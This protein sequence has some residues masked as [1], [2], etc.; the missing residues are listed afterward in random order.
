MKGSPWLEEHPRDRGVDVLD[1][2]EAADVVVIGGGISGLSVA[3]ELLDSTDLSV[4]LMERDL[5]GQGATGHNGGQV[6]AAF[7]RRFEGV[8][9][10]MGRERAA[11]GFREVQ[12]AWDA[13][14]GMVRSLRSPGL[15]QMVPS[16]LGIASPA[17]LRSWTAERRRRG[18]LGMPIGTLRVADDVPSPT[19]SG[20]EKVPREVLEE[21]L[22]TRDRRY[23][24]A[25]GMEIGLMNSY[26]FIELLAKDLLEQHPERFRLF[27]RSPAERLRLSEEEGVASC[28][29]LTVRADRVVLCTNGYRAPPI[30]AC[31]PP[32]ITGRV[33]GVVGYMVGS[34]ALE[35]AA[36]ARAYFRGGDEPYF[37]LTRRE[38]LGGWLTAVGGPEGAIDG[39][40]DPE[41]AYRP[42]AF[43]RLGEFIDETLAIPAGARDHRWQGL[44]GYTPSGVRAV[45]RDPLLPPLYYNIGC[46]GIGLL[47]AVAGAV[48]LARLM[49]GED[50]GP[51]MFD[52]ESAL[53]D[54]RE[55]VVQRNR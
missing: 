46:N 36:G 43:V 48:R 30:E 54:D 42:E 2:H 20:A 55:S 40:Y 49:V 34:T 39:E 31:A 17:D 8:A 52:P 12:G 19:G 51:S 5:V 23:L 50:M 6:V 25:V 41:R 14:G 37:Y 32:M 24:A 22:W 35:G 1:H 15:L 11:Q 10:R 28:R 9:E 29:G 45:G 16:Q 33:E 21:L 4:V 13:L 47:S 18:E 3:R 53:S 26:R 38:H 27:E 44:M 7:E